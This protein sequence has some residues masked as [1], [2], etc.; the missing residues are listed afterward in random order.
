MGE[1]FGGGSAEASGEGDG[2][3]AAAEAD[4]PDG[5]GGSGPGVVGF[6]VDLDEDRCRAWPS[7]VCPGSTP[8]ARPSWVG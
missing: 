6:V 2:A 7:S 4:E 5:P 3:G 8:E 1:V